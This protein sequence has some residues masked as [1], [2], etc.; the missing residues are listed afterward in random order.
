MKTAGPRGP[1][2]KVSRAIQGSPDSSLRTTAPEKLVHI[3]IRMLMA[4]LL[5]MVKL[6]TTQMSMN[7]RMDKKR[8]GWPHGRVVKFA[9]STFSSPGFHQ[10]GSRAWTWH[11]SSGHIEAASHMPQLEGPTTKNIQLCTGGGAGGL[12][13]K[14]KKRKNI[15]KI[16]DHS[17]G[18]APWRRG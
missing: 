10:F 15:K 3:Y 14:R 5:E 12:G 8:G 4:A 13:R 6:E 1:S 2:D 18:P 11:R 17:E 7:K 16:K 9:R